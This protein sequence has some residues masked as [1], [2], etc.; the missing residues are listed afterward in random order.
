MCGSC[1]AVARISICCFPHETIFHFI[2]CFV[3]LIEEDTTPPFKAC[4]TFAHVPA[5]CQAQGCIHTERFRCF[6]TTLPF[7]EPARRRV[8]TRPPHAYN[9][10]GR[11]RQNKERLWIPLVFHVFDNDIRTFSR[12]FTTSWLSLIHI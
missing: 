9:V 4:H 7:S 2:L 12:Y 5:C 6:D 11:R 3:Q 1:A 8:L 10:N